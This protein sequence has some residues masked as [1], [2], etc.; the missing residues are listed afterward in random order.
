M[1]S[2]SFAWVLQLDKSA[3]LTAEHRVSPMLHYAPA[4]PDLRAVNQQHRM[5]TQEKSSERA[6][7]L[8]STLKHAADT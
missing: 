1:L 3:Q 5:K 8:S 2:S 7:T 6:G 4:L